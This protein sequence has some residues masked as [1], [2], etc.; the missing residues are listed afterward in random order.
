VARSLKLPVRHVEIDVLWLVS[1]SS[2]GKFA[3]REVEY[4]LWERLTETRKALSAFGGSFSPCGIAWHGTPR[5]PTMYLRM[6]TLRLC[7]VPADLAK[8]H[9]AST[10]PRERAPL[11]SRIYLSP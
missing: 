8:L 1:R 6:R 11:P 4:V 9:P 2:E 3:V 5:R 7:L 10:L